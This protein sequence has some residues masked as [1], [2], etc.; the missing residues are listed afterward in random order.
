MPRV[1][2]GSEAVDIHRGQLVG[3]RL[4]DVVIVMSLHQLTPVGW[5]RQPTAPNQSFPQ[6][7]PPRP[8]PRLQVQPR[9]TNGFK[10]LLALVDHLVQHSLSRIQIRVPDPVGVPGVERL[11]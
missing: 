8:P 6:P 2:Q 9:V 11:S 5:R 7:H 10:R 1:R 4:K 3:R